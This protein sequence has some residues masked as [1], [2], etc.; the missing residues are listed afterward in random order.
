MKFLYLLAYS[1]ARFKARWPWTQIREL[2][3]QVQRVTEAFDAVMA[4]NVTLAAEKAQ[5][6]D[7]LKAKEL[8]A[9]ELGR[10]LHEER[11]LRYDQES[12]SLELRTEEQ[13]ATIE[14][15]RSS[16]RTLEEKASLSALT[17]LVDGYL[18]TPAPLRLDYLRLFL[19]RANTRAPALRAL[20]LALGGPY[21]AFQKTLQHRG[22]LSFQEIES[23]RDPQHPEAPINNDTLARGI[24]LLWQMV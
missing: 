22:A 17:L 18:M 11:E 16:L 10:L 5:L 6:A 14:G 4:A 2:T 20:V 8:T 24:T 12:R 13:N 7:S 15:L 21:E 3:A 19:G 23:L 9:S 1:W